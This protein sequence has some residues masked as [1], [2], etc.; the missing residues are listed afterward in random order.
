MKNWFALQV[1]TRT[2]TVAFVAL[3]LT[4]LAFATAPEQH[5]CDEGQALKA[6]T[7]LYEECLRIVGKMNFDGDS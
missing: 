6:A 1:E 2:Q 5:F 7:S 3:E 4:K